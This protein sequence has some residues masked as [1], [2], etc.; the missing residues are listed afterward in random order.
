MI[1]LNKYAARSTI[2]DYFFFFLLFSPWS[3]SCSFSQGFPIIAMKHLTLITQYIDL[4]THT[5]SVSGPINN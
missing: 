5:Q 2:N 3:N 4:H 1:S